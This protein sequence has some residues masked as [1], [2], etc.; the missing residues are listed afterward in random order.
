M[1]YETKNLIPSI[2]V[3]AAAISASALEGIIGEFILRDGTDYGLI[4]ISY[5]QKVEQIQRQLIR[6]EVKI[7]FDPNTESV[8]MLTANEWTKL[9]KSQP[10]PPE[11]EL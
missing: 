4:E 1:D 7:I 6:G 9:Q 3:P 5:E 2:E 10:R 8:T 11:A